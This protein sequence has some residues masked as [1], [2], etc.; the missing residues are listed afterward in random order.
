MCYYGSRGCQ[1]WGTCVWLPFKH[2]G[3]RIFSVNVGGPGHFFWF[4]ANHKGGKLVLGPLVSFSRCQL[5]DN[6]VPTPNSET[7]TEPRLVSQVLQNIPTN[8]AFWMRRG[9]VIRVPRMRTHKQSLSILDHPLMQKF[10]LNA[11]LIHLL[12]EFCR[13][14]IVNLSTCL[15]LERFWISTA[16]G[17]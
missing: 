7:G 8:Q 5:S 12:I 4:G 10:L 3:F 14:K 9:R 16:Y 2:K 11:C 17:H 15:E 1:F 6:L 13:A